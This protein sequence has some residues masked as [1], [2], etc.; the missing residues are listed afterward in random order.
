FL[1]DINDCVNHTCQNGG[2][3]VDSINNFT[4]NC[5]K[6]YTGSYCETGHCVINYTS[7]FLSDIDNCVHHT[8]LNGGSCVDGVNNYTCRCNAGFKG[9]R[10]ET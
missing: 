4:C 10:C 7:M 8:C 2:S 3:C 9:D 1:I 5:L 6:G